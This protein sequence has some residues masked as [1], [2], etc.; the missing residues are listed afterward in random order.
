MADAQGASYYSDASIG[1]LLSLSSARLRGA[2][3]ELLAAGLIA[4]GAPF[5]QVLSLEPMPDVPPALP[6][7]A[8]P[9]KSSPPPT[10]CAPSGRRNPNDRLRNLLPHPA[11]SSGARPQPARSA[12]SS[13]SIPRLPP[14]TP[15]WTTT[16]AA[17]PPKM[18][19]SPPSS[20]GSN[21]APTALKSRA[22]HRGRHR[23][24]HPVPSQI[25]RR[26]RRR[27]HRS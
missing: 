3:A 12:A 18:P 9:A 13:A 26:S 23:G 4:Y 21:T 15:P 2:R 6:A 5:D 24:R 22:R 25:I 14:N 7:S 17:V 20:A 1:K 19:S 11:L 27:P 10:S 8:A 16:R